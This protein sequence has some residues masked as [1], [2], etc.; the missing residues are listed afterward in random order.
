MITLEGIV[1]ELIGGLSA[2]I[3]TSIALY[4]WTGRNR[5]ALK[6][7]KKKL[8]SLASLQIEETTGTRFLPAKYRQ[9][10]LESEPT[11]ER[12]KLME[13]LA[14]IS[15]GVSYAEHDFLF[16][17]INRFYQKPSEVRGLSRAE[18]FRFYRILYFREMAPLAW[19]A[20]HP[21][22]P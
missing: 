21:K 19:A 9:V 18:L 22:A 15:R 20:L 16:Q 8:A 14:L 3:F 11:H 7:Q 6:I 12:E 17:M 10:N 2:A 1:N 13:R 4:I 5:A